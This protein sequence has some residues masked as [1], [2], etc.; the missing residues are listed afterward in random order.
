[1]GQGKLALTIRVIWIR[2]DLWLVSAC[3][4]KLKYVSGWQNTRCEATVF[5][6]RL[7]DG[8]SSSM[9]E[10]VSY[11]NP[12]SHTS[13]ETTTSSSLGR[14]G[15]ST[16]PHGP[17]RVGAS[18]S[19]AV[20]YRPTRAMHACARLA[21]RNTWPHTMLLLGRVPCQYK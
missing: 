6:N 18:T 8:R 19:S 2:R 3:H 20:Q 10:I 4:W 7:T 17:A 11:K 16:R 14:T 1:M 9:Q 21:W 15:A 12:D 13:P 5:G